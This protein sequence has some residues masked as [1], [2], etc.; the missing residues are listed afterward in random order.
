MT[1]VKYERIFE[2]ANIEHDYWKGFPKEYIP[3]VQNL[4]KMPTSK[5][6]LKVQRMI[7]FNIADRIGLEKIAFEL[8]DSNYAD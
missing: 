4:P 2:M 5:L 1:E 7:M 3:I 8:D 6:S